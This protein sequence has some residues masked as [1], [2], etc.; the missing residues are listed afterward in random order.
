MKS[1]KNNVQYHGDLYEDEELLTKDD[2][3]IIV[4]FCFPI[5]FVAGMFVYMVYKY[6][7]FLG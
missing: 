5:A 1:Y 7:I 3:K 4:A 6:T 2:M